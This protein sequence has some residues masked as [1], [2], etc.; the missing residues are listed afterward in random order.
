MR[1]WL[2]SVATAGAAL[3]LAGVVG[4]ARADSGTPT[5]PAI[6]VNG[7]GAQGV[8]EGASTDQVAAAYRAALAQALADAKAKAMLIAQ[9]E[10]VTLG[11]VTGVTEQSSEDVGP[12]RVSPPPIVNPGGPLRPLPAAK[13]RVARPARAV[14]AGRQHAKEIAPAPTCQEIA[15]V[16]VVYAFS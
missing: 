14:R 3:A 11:A 8:S 13:A 5:P 6:S 4:T 12:C 10:G 7:V 15:N 1:R 16:T 9:T 2:S